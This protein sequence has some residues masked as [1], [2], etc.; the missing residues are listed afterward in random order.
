M[1]E[2]KG[3][4]KFGNQLPKY[5]DPI[6]KRGWFIINKKPYDNQSE[7]LIIDLDMNFENT[8][9]IGYIC[10]HMKGKHTKTVDF[11]YKHLLS[12]YDQDSYKRADD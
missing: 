1:S 7:L 5:P 4:P 10:V 8:E 11:D 6:F 3:L 9:V 2:T 12:I